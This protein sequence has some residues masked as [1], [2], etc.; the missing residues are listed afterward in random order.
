[1]FRRPRRSTKGASLLGDRIDLLHNNPTSRTSPT[2]PHYPCISESGSVT[3]QQQQRSHIRRKKQ[4]RCTSLNGIQSYVCRRDGLKMFVVVTTSVVVVCS[5]IWVSQ[6]S[7]LLQML[8]RL[9]PNVTRK[10]RGPN[11]RRTLNQLVPFTEFP[12]V[13][14]QK[15]NVKQRFTTPTKVRSINGR[16]DFGGIELRIAED[17]RYRSQ[18]RVVYHDYHADLGYTDLLAEQRDDDAEE[19]MESYYAFDDDAKRN[20]Y[21]EYDDPDI[22]QHKQCRRTSWHRDVPLNCNTLHEFDFSYHITSGRT[23]FLGYVFI[24]RLPWYHIVQS[25]RSQYTSLYIYS[26][27]AYRQVYLT[28]GPAA[29]IDETFVLK[30]FALDS[31]F[32]YD[33]YE[34]VRMDA[35]VNEKLNG[36]AR[37]VS[38]YSYCGISVTSEA[39][40]Q[41][42]MEHVAVPTGVGRPMKSIPHDTQPLTVRNT[43]SGTQKLV[44]SLEMAEAVLLLHTYSGGVMV[45]DDIQLSQFL[46]SSSGQLKLNDFNRAEI[47]LWN[48]K[49]NEYCKYRNHPGG[50]DVSIHVMFRSVTDKI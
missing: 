46:L 18:Q 31:D 12:V 8:T 49:D 44:R 27:G 40:L 3:L 22:H 2:H 36:H 50:G 48:E 37:I 35:N 41:G 45:H 23:K 13:Y 14:S 5:F 15:G 9:S 6:R 10:M 7:L 32:S 34:F 1:M 28:A 19:E 38:M 16:P 20:P 21:H 17:Q 29:N 47:M 25:H 42:D 24:D 33:G 11:N 26:A 43:L 39:M 30:T 4:H